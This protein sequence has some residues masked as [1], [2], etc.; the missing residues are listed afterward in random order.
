LIY[1]FLIITLGVSLS[2]PDHTE[3]LDVRSVKNNDNRVW[4]QVRPVH[5]GVLALSTP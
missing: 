1:L 4:L 3:R 5:N 2:P